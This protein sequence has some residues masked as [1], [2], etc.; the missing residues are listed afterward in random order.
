MRSLFLSF[1]IL[2]C[3]ASPPETGVLEGEIAIGL[4]APVRGG[5]EV[6]L[7][8][9]RGVPVVLVFWA[10]WCAPCMA[11]IP[12]LNSLVEEY[13]D[14]I[15]VLGVNMGENEAIVYMTQK[16]KGMQYSSVMDVSGEI[17][18]A[19]RV[20][21]LPMMLVLDK[22]GRIRFRGLGTQQQLTLLLDS[23]VVD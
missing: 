21:K 8:S 4:S 9:F 2:A 22:E 1:M 3:S 18:S 17:A 5:E 15:K 13:G 23:L 7:N 6:S 10:S 12:H 19:W 14:A 20:R 16:Q 11:E